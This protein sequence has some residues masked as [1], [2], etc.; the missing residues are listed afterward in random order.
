MTVTQRAQLTL[1]KRSSAH[2]AKAIG[3]RYLTDSTPGLTRIKIGNSFRYYGPTGRPVRRSSD[4]Q[5]FRSLAIPP[6]WKDVWISPAANSH[7]QATGRDAKGRKQYRYHP[8]WRTIRDENKYAR[9]LMVGEI[10]PKLRARV[11]ND[12][13]LQG[14]PRAKLVATVVR[15]LETTLIRIGNVEYARENNSFGLT[16]FKIAT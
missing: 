1:L 10:L 16:T 3:L 14:L 7:L 2:A 4:L 13:A 6:A 9:M 12:L 15:L 8:S 5:R 11:R